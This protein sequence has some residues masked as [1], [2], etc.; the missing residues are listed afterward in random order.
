MANHFPFAAESVHAP[1]TDAE[2]RTY[3]LL[4]AL[5]WQHHPEADP[6]YVELTYAELADRHLK[7]VAV[8]TLRV[9]V[10]TLVKL[11]YLR[12]EQVNRS[13]WRTYV[14][15][16]APL[17]PSGG[18]GTKAFSPKLPD[19]AGQPRPIIVQRNRGGEET[20]PSADSR[21]GDR[22]MIT[23]AADEGDRPVITLDTEEGDRPMI[24][25]D[26]DEGDRHMITLGAGEGDRPMITLDADE[27]DRPVITLAADEG[28]RP[29]ITLAVA[30]KGD[31]PVITLDDKT[32]QSSVPSLSWGDMI[33]QSVNLTPY[34]TGDTSQTP[35]PTAPKGRLFQR[36]TGDPVLARG[37]ARERHFFQVTSP[38]PDR[39][40]ITQ[41]EPSADSRQPD[42]P[43]ITLA[44][45]AR[46]TI[47]LDGGEGDHPTITLEPDHPVITLNV[48]K[49]DRPVI[50]LV[51]HDRPVITLDSA[52]G[53]RPTI[54]LEPDRPVITLNASK[55]DRPMIT[56][57]EPDRPVITLG[58]NLAEGDRGLITQTAE[59]DRPAITLA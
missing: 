18:G 54:T 53:D 22:P 29:M 14:T 9:R 25:L 34:L 44:E 35:E 8:P 39:P 21:Q 48:T 42:R 52:E 38:K 51:E 36:D 49:G 43:A 47:T 26:A 15:G 4:C 32:A 27:G 33:R 57:V 5:A 30:P 46:P 20:K 59:G 58:G 2:F 40:V 37:R 45:P 7:P 3:V 19:K 6:P 56:L 12:R 16:L 31:R 1:V 13:T 41:E 28:D 23:L 24:T 17:P 55:G 10:M 11:G 50:T